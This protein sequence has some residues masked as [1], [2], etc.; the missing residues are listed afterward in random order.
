MTTPHEDRE[1]DILADWI[2][3]Y[4][5][6]IERWPA[7]VAATARTLAAR[8]PEAQALLTRTQALDDLLAADPVVPDDWALARTTRR[9]MADLEDIED[10]RFDWRSVFG[11]FTVRPA[12]VI[13][14]CGIMVG[15]AMG[16]MIQAP[17]PVEL[18]LPGL[19]DRSIL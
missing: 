1:L 13:L 15:I 12:L 2:D 9:V 6:R 14:G 10:Q 7:A 3:R 4:G 17:P 16:V 8:S 5:A 19:G 11:L 18:A